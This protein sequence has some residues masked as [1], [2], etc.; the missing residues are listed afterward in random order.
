MSPIRRRH[1]EAVPGRHKRYHR[2]MSTAP[3]EFE[4]VMIKPSHYDDDGYPITWWRGM[5]PSNSLAAL[6]GI[7]ADCAERRVLGPDVAINLTAYRRDQPPHRPGANR[8]RA[9]AGAGAKALIG[10][11]GV[12]SNQYDRALDLAREFRAAGLPVMIGGFHVSGCLAMLKEMP[13][14]IQEALDIGLLDLRRRMRGRAARRGASR[15]L[16]RQPEARLQLP[17]RPAQPRRRAG[18]GAARRRAPAQI[19]DWSSFDLGRGCPFQCS[20]CTIINVQGRKSRFRTADDLEAIVRE[21]VAQGVKALLHH[22]RQ[23]RPQPPLGG[24]LRPADRAA[25]D[26]RGSRST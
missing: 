8:P 18:A 14:E 19:Q 23:S 12:Q 10:L 5:I 25:R 16:E 4:F 26:R 15:R 21:N 22:R 17:R 20:F 9:C 6:N 2:R 13:P 24:V 11:V 7:A 3:P 1:D